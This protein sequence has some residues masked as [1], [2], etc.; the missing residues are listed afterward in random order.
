MDYLTLLS[1]A[2]ALAIAGCVLLWRIRHEDY[3]SECQHCR[4]QA[5]LA[6]EKKRADSIEYERQRHL[7]FH[8]GFGVKM[9]DVK[10]CP[11]CAKDSP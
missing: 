10:H 6:A 8:R 11:T 9:G 5:W 7:A 3:C 4:H 2:L 1:V